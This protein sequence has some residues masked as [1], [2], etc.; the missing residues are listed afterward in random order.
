M[1]MALRC[2]VDPSLHLLW[3]VLLECRAVEAGWT[4]EKM[5]D[6]DLIELEPTQLA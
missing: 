5:F 1:E 4:L 2:P 3:R 6:G